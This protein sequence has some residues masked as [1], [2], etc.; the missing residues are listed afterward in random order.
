LV[1]LTFLET[2]VWAARLNSFTLAA[3]RSNITQ[4]AVSSRIAALEDELGVKLFVREHRK[5]R[6]TSVGLQALAK[7][8]SLLG[9]AHLFENEI[10]KSSG[11]R[12][13]VRIGVIDTISYTWLVDLIHLSNDN[14][15]RI[16]IEIM[17]ETSL[18]LIDMLRDDEIDVALLMGPFLDPGYIS[19]ELC[20]YACHW[21]AAPA[22]GLSDGKIALSTLVAH[23]IISFPKGS[24]PHIAIHRFFEQFAA[25]EIVVHSAN[26]VATI[27]RM[28]IDGLGVATIPPVVAPRELA[29]GDLV[30]IDAQQPIP[31]M[32]FHAVYRESS[33]QRIPAMI[34]ELAREVA[35]SFCRQSNPLWAWDRP[36][37]RTE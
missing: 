10:S 29:R 16:N 17:A 14:F 36:S 1:N 32:R 9:Q 19:V 25:S 3:E 13:T 27:I 34:A 20:T 4:A 7:A 26:S 2:F 5:L 23:P 6:L 11:L 33:T 37:Q 15:P 18:R 21:V 24:Q 8:E 35:V 31:P 28:T 30:L 22:L 12:G